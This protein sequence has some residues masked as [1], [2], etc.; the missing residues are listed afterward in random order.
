MAHLAAIDYTTLELPSPPK[1]LFEISALLDGD[2]VNMLKMS[3]LIETD[4]ALAAA[5]MKTI[6]SPM[7]GLRG[8]AQNVHQAITFLGTREV[9]ALVYQVSLRSAFPGAAEL[10]PM[11]ERSAVRA[12]LM[13]R[14]AKEVYLDVWCAHTAG[15]FEECGKA[16]LFKLAPETY[17]PMMKKAKDDIELVALE[18]AE[19]GIS[20]DQLGAKL[21]ESWGLDAGAVACVRGHVETLVSK[22][23]P[24]SSP[25]RAISVIS[26]LVHTM[27]TAPDQLEAMAQALAPQAML[28]QALLLKGARRVKQKVDDAINDD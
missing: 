11:W 24:T 21:C 10:Q 2:D 12:L 22:R 18:Q 6:S 3:R 27:G 14:L 9:A 19:F 17:G 13:G 20:H 28:D 15:L 7:Y 23:L 1:T 26:A 5:V 16:V 4:L 8:R 25:R